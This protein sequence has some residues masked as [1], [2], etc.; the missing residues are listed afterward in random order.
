[1]GFAFGYWFKGQRLL[2]CGIVVWGDPFRGG[3]SLVAI[4][5][6]RSE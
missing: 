5:I 3:Y 6:Y 1:M 4:I 2:G